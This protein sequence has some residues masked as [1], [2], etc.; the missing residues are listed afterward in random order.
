MR[1]VD[2]STFTKRDSRG[3]LAVRTLI[4]QRPISGNAVATAA[5]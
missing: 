1:S 4:A 3:V 2:S 5:L